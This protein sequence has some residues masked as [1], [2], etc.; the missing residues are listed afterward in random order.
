MLRRFLGL[1]LLTALVGCATTGGNPRDPFEGYNR[2]MFGFNDGLDKVV[3]KP[4]ATGYKTVMPEIARTG[5]TNF[6]SNLSDIWIG[7]NNVL[8]GKVEAGAGDFVRFLVNS[9]VGVVGL[10]DVASKTGLEKHNEDFGQTL[11]RWGVGSGPYVVLPILGPSDVRDGLSTLLVDWRGY[12]IWYI[13]DVAVRNSLIVFRFIDARANLLDI[14]QLAEEAALD[15]YAYVRDAYLQR[16]RSLIYDGNPPPEAEPDKGSESGASTGPAHAETDPSPAQ[17][18]ALAGVR[19]IAAADEELTQ[20]EEYPGAAG[21][22]VAA[23]PAAAGA[24]GAVYDPRI[25]NNYEAVLAI[26]RTEAEPPSVRP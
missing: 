26:S 18:T 15:H 6:F 25:P 22:P 8:Q 24:G 23:I 11:G 17:I 21:Q 16:R 3:F 20:A 19:V 12:P 13:N 14:S 9:T 4:V 10:F 2:A 7:V 5:V 1:M